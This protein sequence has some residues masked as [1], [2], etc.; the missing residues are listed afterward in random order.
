MALRFSITLLL[1]VGAFF[2][3]WWLELFFILAATF[4]LSWYYEGV[5]GVLLYELIYA[6]HAENWW[7]VLV[8]ILIV[9]VVEFIKSRLYV[10][11]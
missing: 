3:P 5:I 4:Y 1:I 9:P 2:L 8:L 7:P 10:F 11:H 6:P